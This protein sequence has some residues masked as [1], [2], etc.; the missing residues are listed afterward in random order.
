MGFNEFLV[1]QAFQPVPWA[2]LLLM[3]LAGK[4]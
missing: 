1:A 2:I 4:P 3:R